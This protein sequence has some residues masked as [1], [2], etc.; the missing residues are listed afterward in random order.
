[1]KS[2]SHT[3]TIAQ[4]IEIYKLI[5]LAFRW[6]VT[7]MDETSVRVSHEAEA[8]AMEFYEPFYISD[9]R[10]PSFEERFLGYG[11]T[12]SSQVISSPVLFIR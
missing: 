7:Y 10:I 3:N 8:K 5:C 9:Y 2:K 4:S 11:F 12:R 6:S 1:M